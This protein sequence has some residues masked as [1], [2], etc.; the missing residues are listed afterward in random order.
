MRSRRGLALSMTFSLAF[1]LAFWPMLGGSALAED[2]VLSPGQD[3]GGTAVAVIADGFD[4]A[5]SDLAAILARDGEGEAIAWDAVDGDHRPFSRDGRGTDAALAAAVYGGVRIVPVRADLDDHQSLAKGI[6]FA[7]GTPA[8]VV[9][10][11]LGSGERA[12]LDVVIAAARRFGTL[13]LVASLPGL[14]ADEAKRGGDLAN[15][16]LLDSAENAQTAAEAIARVLR[17]DRGALTGTTGAELKSALLAGLQHEP[18][19]GC[20]P[21]GGA[22]AE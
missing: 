18:P 8:R 13:L 22:K 15:L 6:A 20:E 14:T 10:V 17:C 4:Y 16:A 19:A 11:P 7:A 2:P 3:P 1:S 21:S 5:R 9:L 12:G